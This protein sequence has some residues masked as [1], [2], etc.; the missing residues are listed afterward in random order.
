MSIHAAHHGNWP[1]FLLHAECTQTRG[2]YAHYLLAGK[3]KDGFAINRAMQALEQQLKK[4]V[5]VQVCS[6]IFA[7]Y[8]V[9]V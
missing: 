7:S 5:I 2:A 9:N 1:C 6:G 8:N 4:A 3:L